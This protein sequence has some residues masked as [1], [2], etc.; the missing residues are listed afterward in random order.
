VWF[1][2]NTPEL[3]ALI[4]QTAPTFYALDDISLVTVPGPIAG[5]GL[6][7]LILACGGLLGWWR[8]RQKMVGVTAIKSKLSAALAAASCALTCPRLGLT[9]LAAVNSMEVQ[10]YFS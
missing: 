6:P 4:Y 8:R 1:A 3:F 5:A 10:W 2:S 9:I 7:G